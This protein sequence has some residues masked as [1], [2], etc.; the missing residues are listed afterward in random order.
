MDQY[1]TCSKCGLSK[2]LNLFSKDKSKKSGYTASCLECR[3][4]YAKTRRINNLDF[5][6]KA[7]ASSRA[8]YH[9][10]KERLKRNYKKWVKGNP[11]LRREIDKRFREKNRESQRERAVDYR[12][13]N[14]EKRK[15]WAQKNP[16]K[17]TAIYARRSFQVRGGERFA[18][19]LKEL[20]KMYAGKCSYCGSPAAHIDHIIPLSR[21]GQHRIGNLTPACA[22]CNLSKGSK[23]LMEWKKGTWK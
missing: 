9:A 1:K 5:A 22:S 14:P 4:S 15:E 23:F 12:S 19:S 18:V 3:A 16:E 2:T 6:E 11:N 20:A 21:G 7:N 13:R 8:Y 10:N 17:Q